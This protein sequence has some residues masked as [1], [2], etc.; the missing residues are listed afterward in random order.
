MD[1]MAG[2]LFGLTEVVVLCSRRQRGGRDTWSRFQISKAWSPNARRTIF[3]RAI[4]GWRSWAGIRQE[5]GRCQLSTTCWVFE[6]SVGRN[7]MGSDRS[8]TSVSLCSIDEFIFFCRS[9][10]IP[11]WTGRE[12]GLSGVSTVMF[13]DLIWV[14]CILRPCSQLQFSWVFFN[15]NLRPFYFGV[16]E[17]LIFNI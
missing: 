8:V 2:L 1:F 12:T 11:Q 14:L 9:L 4:A 5:Q 7:P 6:S 16:I 17:I 15:P 3:G 10:M 13:I